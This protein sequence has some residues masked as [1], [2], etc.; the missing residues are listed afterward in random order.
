MERHREDDALYCGDGCWETIS[1]V[2]IRKCR[3]SLDDILVDENVEDHL[4]TGKLEQNEM[5]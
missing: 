3:A 2:T 1:E 4:Q 5:A